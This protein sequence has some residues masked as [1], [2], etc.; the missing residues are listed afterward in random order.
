M[1]TLYIELNQQSIKAAIE[2]L[3][4]AKKKVG[5]AWRAFLAASC[6]WIIKRAN[7]Y[8]DESEVGIN[9]INDIKA[10][11]TY[12]VSNNGAVIINSSPKAAYVEFGV[13]IIGGLDKHPMADDAGYDYNRPSPYKD[14]QGS[15]HFF[16]NEA[17]LDI[18]EDAFEAGW[19]SGK[20][21]KRHR[22]HVYTRGVEGAMYAFN[23]VE[24]YRTSG[25]IQRLWNEAGERY[26]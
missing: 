15:W 24:D 8:V 21:D 11:W 6:E 22:M 17:D 4:Q 5:D 12:T 1:K 10:S 2:R 14:A 13:G 20:T 3:K 25:I 18:P 26:L 9:V 19:D 7:E 16:S 23:A